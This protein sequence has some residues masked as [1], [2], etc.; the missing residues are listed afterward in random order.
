MLVQ[1][2]G[3]PGRA[4]VSLA[5]HLP[6]KLK[7]FSV[8]CALSVALFQNPEGKMLSNNESRLKNINPWLFILEDTQQRI[9]LMTQVLNTSWNSE[10]WNLVSSVGMA[11]PWL[12][13]HYS[14]LQVIS[15]D[16]DLFPDKEEKDPGVGMDVV[17]WLEKREPTARI[18]IH[19]A[20]G[21]AGSEMFNRL[22]R[23]G[24]T[25]SRVFPTVDEAWITED[26]L[27]AVHQLKNWGREA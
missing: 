4:D 16:H 7:T 10:S 1:G 27:K 17:L 12:E 14:G 13:K 23:Q 18:I 24:F 20:N 22:E 11:L 9:D 6:T 26:W 8:T 3:E 21:P 2:S 15:L 5:G 19:S 25:V